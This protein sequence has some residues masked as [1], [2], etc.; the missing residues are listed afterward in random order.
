MLCP[1]CGA[2]LRE[3]AIFCHRCGRKLATQPDAATPSETLASEETAQTEIVPVAIDAAEPASG[4]SSRGASANRAER[5][6]HTPPALRL[7]FIGTHA[8]PLAP[9]APPSP[10]GDDLEMVIAAETME[11]PL[12]ATRQPAAQVSAP[13]PL[14]ADTV[15]AERYRILRLVEQDDT[16]NVYQVH[17][18]WADDRCWECQ[19]PLSAGDDP[20]CSQCGAERRSP[21]LFL[22]EGAPARMD[23]ALEGSAP[24]FIAG[25][26]LYA[27]MTG[28]VS[29]SD[30]DP[31]SSLREIPQVPEPLPIAEAEPVESDDVEELDQA[32]TM[33]VPTAPAEAADETHPLFFTP[34]SLGLM[35]QSA[36]LEAPP[37]VMQQNDAPTIETMILNAETWQPR[38]T[39]DGPPA[40][41]V[42]VPVTP[43]LRLGVASDVGRARR[44]RAN[45][46]TAVVTTLTHAGS[47]APAPLTL[48]VVADGL[49]G[50]DEG[51][52]AGRLAARII[53]AQ[54]IQ[55]L[56]LPALAGQAALEFDA[57]GLGNVLLTAIQEANTQIL[58][59]NIAE[60]CDMGCTVTAL[61]AQ[62]SA[63]CAANV[64]DSRTYR[65]NAQGL[66]RVTIDHSLVARLVA[67]GML[68]PDDVYTHPQRSQIYR[69]LGDEA[70]IPIDLFPLRLEPDETFIL[71]SDGLWEMV[72]DPDIAQILADTQG[73]DPQSIAEQLINVA[74]DH[75]GEDNVSVIVAQAVAL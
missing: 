18:Q 59:I 16:G 62:G 43:A 2:T 48:C 20:F 44:G 23:E 52:R 74:N 27:I 40:G 54:V 68:A 3:T 9:P 10:P 63:A 69:S 46:D 51:Q 37:D 70:E 25:D 61:I 1:V 28:I 8:K 65:F 11:W 15:I 57:V 13:E 55:H 5:N 29:A 32:R 75:G 6:I 60:N 67:A 36:D 49:G 24:T 21:I 53:V 56:W 39:P 72:R 14:P 47:A 71:C 34:E 30:P 35:P 38:L 31:A 19:S 33:E 12:D 42:P 7:P 50:H 26:R 22:H 41:P 64:G 66:S 73:S 45:E 58:G 17:D 4:K